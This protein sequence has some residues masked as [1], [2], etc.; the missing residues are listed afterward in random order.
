MHE[1][2]GT[3]MAVLP[4]VVQTDI[5]EFG[6]I[7]S[8]HC[9]KGTLFTLVRMATVR[10]MLMM[11]RI[12]AP[13]SHHHHHDFARGFCSGVEIGFSDVSQYDILGHFQMLEPT[14]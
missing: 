6:W 9:D 12:A 14:K 8:P 5:S 11:L 10:E 13:I 1:A 2:T 3:I 4:I 7:G